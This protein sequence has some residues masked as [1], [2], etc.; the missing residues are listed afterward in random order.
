MFFRAFS[1]KRTKQFV[2]NLCKDDRPRRKDLTS[3]KIIPSGENKETVSTK[4]LGIGSD[5]NFQAASTSR[6]PLEIEFFNTPVASGS[7]HFRTSH[8]HSFSFEDGSLDPNSSPMPDV[9]S[10]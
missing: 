5:E 3:V 6:V 1:L 9:S 10:C 8:F 7:G 4:K 2:H